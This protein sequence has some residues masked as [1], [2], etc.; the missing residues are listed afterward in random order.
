M[1]LSHLAEYAGLRLLMSLATRLSPV[2]ATRVGDILGDLVFY[3]TG[4]RKKLVMEH[5][6]RVYGDAGDGATPRS[7]A[8]SV[9]RQ[10][11]RTAVEHARLLAGKTSD[12]RDRLT[13]SGEEHIA[14]ARQGG[15]GVILITGHFGYWELLGATVALLGYP[16]TVV[17]KKLHN[18]AVDRLMHGGRERLGMS[19]ASMDSAPPVILKALRRNEC[20]GLLADQDAGPGGVFVEFLGLRA[21]TYQGPALFALRTGAPIV[22]CFII[23]SGPER[24][25]V[26]FE[27]PIETTPTGDEPADIARITQAYTDVLA[28]YILDYPDHWFWVHRRWKTPMPADSSHVQ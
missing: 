18:P 16:V 28:R 20:V 9:Y 26:C 14:R 10:L 19:V 25:R 13:I 3:V 11:G 6:G 8:R 21:S 7:R 22:P 2:L 4:M 23:R 24:H 12:L 27:T 15:R 1:K 5:L 17:A